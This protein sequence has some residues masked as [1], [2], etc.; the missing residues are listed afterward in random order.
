MRKTMRI[1]SLL[2]ATALAAACLLSGPALF[3]HSETAGP[4]GEVVVFLVRHA[5]KIDA[6]VA[7]D[8]RNPHL[9]DDG[10][11]RAAELA[12][13]LGDSGVTA[14]HSTS[15][16]RTI[17]TARP[18]ANRLGLEI[19]PYDPTDLRSFAGALRSS[20]GR[21]LVVGHSNT[22]PQLV[23]LLGGEPGAPIV[24]ADEYDRLYVLVIRGD[25]TT[26]TILRFG[27]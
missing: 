26:S 3:A 15:Y 18:L 5:E 22:T 9:D 6:A 8:P 19:K 12:R 4:T 16:H 17:E 13:V 23:E 25:E 14:I 11:H 2:P 7:D 10:L 24:E 1:L 21:H 20:A 27:E